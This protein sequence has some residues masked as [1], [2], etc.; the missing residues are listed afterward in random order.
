MK[1]HFCEKYNIHIHKWCRGEKKS[2]ILKVDGEK[3]SAEPG[4]TLLV[5]VVGVHTMAGPNQA[6]CVAQSLSGSMV[7]RAPWTTRS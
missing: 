6:S 7:H 3:W 1:Y 2:C 5:S 4:L